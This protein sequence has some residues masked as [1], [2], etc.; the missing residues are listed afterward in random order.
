MEKVSKY[1][2]KPW[3]QHVV[4]IANGPPRINYIKYYLITTSEFS[5]YTNVEIDASVAHLNAEVASKLNSTTD[6]LTAKIDESKKITLKAVND[7]K[8][9]CK[10]FT[11]QEVSG[12]LQAFSGSSNSE[13][14]IALEKI[15]DDRETASLK[16]NN[17]LIAELK[18]KISALEDRLNKIVPITLS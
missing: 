4:S 16:I 12:I 2:L 11:T 10:A 13:M 8:D 14:A 5:V 1:Q 7:C 15:V 18:S 3:I 9:A 17:D 6:S